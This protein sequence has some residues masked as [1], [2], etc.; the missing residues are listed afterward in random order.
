MSKSF[1]LGSPPHQN[2]S[3]LKFSIQFIQLHMK[4]GGT[5]PHRD[6]SNLTI[7]RNCQQILK[8]IHKTFG[9]THPTIFCPGWNGSNSKRDETTDGSSE[10]SPLGIDDVDVTNKGILAGMNGSD[11][12]HFPLASGG[13]FVNFDYKISDF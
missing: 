5:T 6:F 11:F 1:N 13:C 9:G 10:S 12:C 2:F 3:T 8:L 7:E 4:L